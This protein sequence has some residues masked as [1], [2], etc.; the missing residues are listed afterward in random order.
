[1]RKVDALYILLHQTFLF[2][3]PL[4]YTKSLTLP[5]SDNL[6]YWNVVY[7]LYFI[8]KF[9]SLHISSNVTAI[10]KLSAKTNS[11]QDLTSTRN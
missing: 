7:V 2:N 10:A 5:P 11:G 3:F 8:A 6:I 1:M 9:H 4:T